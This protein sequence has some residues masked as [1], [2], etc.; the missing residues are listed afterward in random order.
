M[1][2]GRQDTLHND[3]QH[4]HKIN[5]TLITMSAL[6]CLVSFMLSAANQPI[7]LSVIMSNVIMLSVM[8]PCTVADDVFPTLCTPPTTKNL[9]LPSRRKTPNLFQIFMNEGQ[10]G[11]NVA[12]LLLHFV[13]Y[14]KVQI[15]AE[16]NFFQISNDGT[17]RFKKM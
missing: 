3:I 9:N 16:T 5:A 17:A 7:M 14:F 11:L 12:S 15:F 8:A 2:T 13:S 1:C 4:N 6:S 10:A